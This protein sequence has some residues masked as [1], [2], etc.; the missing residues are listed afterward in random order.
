LG[1]PLDALG[2]PSGPLGA[3]LGGLKS[4]KMQTALCE[5]HFFENGPFRFLELL[6]ALLASSW[7]LLG[8]SWAQTGPQNYPK[9]GPKLVRKLVQKQGRFLAVF[10]PI[11]GPVLGTKMGR[12]GGPVFEGFPGWL[13]MA[14]LGS[15]L[16]RLG[17]SWR[18]LGA[19]LAP[20]W[21]HLGPSW[22]ILAPSWRHLGPF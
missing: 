9:S 5:N 16:A 3:V 20:S 15:I 7:R 2:Q 14:Y 8:R 17:P 21:R 11:L 19:I 1:A 10:G 6:L 22:P 12:C 13:Q 18:P 4:E